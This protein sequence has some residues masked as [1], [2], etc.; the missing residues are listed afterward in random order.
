M[1]KNYLRGERKM[2]L[3]EIKHIIE[4]E[5]RMSKEKIE[6]GSPEWE[7]LFKKIKLKDDKNN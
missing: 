5:N 4:F 1:L 3:E 7:V 6:I 2:K